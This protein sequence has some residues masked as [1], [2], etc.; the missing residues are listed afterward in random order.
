MTFEKYFP[1]SFVGLIFILYS[2]LS[3]RMIHTGPWARGLH[4]PEARRPR[5]HVQQPHL[6]QQVVALLLRQIQ[7]G[8]GWLGLGL[9]WV[10]GLS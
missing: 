2:Y 10:V 1:S 4:R 3:T 6:V 7:S 8:W 9:G 5:A